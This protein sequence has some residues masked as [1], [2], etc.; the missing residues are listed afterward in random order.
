MQ[1][2]EKGRRGEGEGIVEARAGCGIP[3][4][5]WV[6]RYGFARC[7][8]GFGGEFGAFGG[9]GHVGVAV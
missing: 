7:D 4:P 5:L 1:R 6:V 3:H 2:G 8:D 9:W